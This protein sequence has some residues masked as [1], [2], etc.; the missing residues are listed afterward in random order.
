MQY[1]EESISLLDFVP[2]KGKKY[3]V[4]FGNEVDDVDLEAIKASDKVIEI[5]QFGTKHSLNV[6]VSLGIVVWDM[7]AKWNAQ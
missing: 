7:L 4:V 2:E 3:G 6:S 1:R 5:P